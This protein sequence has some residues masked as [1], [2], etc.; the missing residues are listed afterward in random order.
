M[1]AS[2]KSGATASQSAACQSKRRDKTQCLKP[3]HPTDSSVD[4][5]PACLMHSR[6]PKKLDHGSLLFVEFF[7]E[8]NRILRE[9][10]KLHTDAGSPS[11]P[12]VWA[13]FSGFVFPQISWF[14]RKVPTNCD[15]RSATFTGDANFGSATFTGAANFRGATFSEAADFRKATFSEAADFGATTFS[16][17]AKFRGAKFRGAANFRGATFSGAASFGLATFSGAA[18]FG[19]ATFTGDAYLF[20]ATFT[21]AADF[22]SATFTGAANFSDATFT[23]AADFRSATFTEA[24]DFNFATFIGAAAFDSAKFHKTAV[25]HSATFHQAA[26][27]VRTKFRTDATLEAGPYFHWTQFEKPEKALFSEVDLGR[28][29]FYRA[30]VAKLRFHNVT[31]RQHGSDSGGSKRTRV[32]LFE[33]DVDI[34]QHYEEGDL[35]EDATEGLRQDSG[36]ASERNYRVIADLYQQLK[37]NYEDRRDYATAG[38]FHY[39]EMEMRRLDSP[40]KHKLLRWFD[41]NA[42]PTALYKYA[43]S[44]GESFAKPALWLGAILLAFAVLYTLTGMTYDAEKDRGAQVQSMAQRVSAAPGVPP[45]ASRRVVEV[46]WR[47]PAVFPPQNTPA[48]Y[49]WARLVLFGHGLMTALYVAA[50]QKDLVFE[51]SYPLGRIVALVELALTSTFIAL[52]L[53]AVRRRFQR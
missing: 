30:E 39:G 17:A 31:W 36:D 26:R 2:V 41:R 9:A 19:S 18:D 40:H 44:Y 35:A 46:S 1:S 14:E 24:A 23:G 42:G 38:D 12:K 27:F 25:F 13:D 10:D 16:D 6:D 15:F 3:V 37:K 28:A 5:A 50:F 43:S 48:A 11:P 21:G 49:G 53:L 20:S 51:P 47:N 33:E 7:A 34:Q 32:H 29:L 4:P 45:V 8:V 22:S 52:F